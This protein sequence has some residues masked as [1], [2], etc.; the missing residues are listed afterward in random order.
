VVEGDREAA[1]PVFNVA[2]NGI[3]LQRS[4]ALLPVSSCQRL[5]WLLLPWR[6]TPITPRRAG[7]ETRKPPRLTAEHEDD[8]AARDKEAEQDSDSC[9]GRVAGE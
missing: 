3:G 7:P 2:T 1:L 5:W 6:R 4:I 9:R 8:D